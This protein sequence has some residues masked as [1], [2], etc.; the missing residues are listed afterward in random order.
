MPEVI[1]DPNEGLEQFETADTEDK[2]VFTKIILFFAL[3]LAILVDITGIISAVIDV[4]T[5]GIGGWIIRIVFA[6]FKLFYL[7]LFWY[8]SNVFDYDGSKAISQEIKNYTKGF[9]WSA[10]LLGI[11]SVVSNFIPIIG[12]VIDALPIETLNIVFLFF[13]WPAVIKKSQNT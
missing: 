5:L 11:S 13:I 2:S 3:G 10:R 1:H 6:I 7:G 9:I 4:G 8:L 12:S